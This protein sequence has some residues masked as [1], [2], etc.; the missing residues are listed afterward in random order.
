[1]EDDVLARLTTFPNVLITSHQAFFT[2][3]ALAEIA[4]ATARGIRAFFDARPLEN[5]I[6]YQCCEGNCERKTTGRCFA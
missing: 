3:E 4:A 2:R 1:V 5:E 6:C